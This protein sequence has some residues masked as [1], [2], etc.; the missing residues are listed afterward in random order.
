MDVETAVATPHGDATAAT[1]AMHDDVRKQI[2]GL[3]LSQRLLIKQ[4]L[5]PQAPTQPTTTPSVSI[6]FEYCLIRITRP[7]LVDAFINNG[8]WCLPDVAKGQLTAPNKFGATLPLLPIAAVAVRN[9]S[10]SGNWTTEDVGAAAISTDFGP[11]KVDGA[12]VNNSL[13]HAG[14]QIIG[15][16]LQRMPPLPPNDPGL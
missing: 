4:F 16:L 3:D 6:T 15:W 11:F 13:S 8:L 7:W 12:I 2:S 5:V 9:L 14:I 1:F 10:I